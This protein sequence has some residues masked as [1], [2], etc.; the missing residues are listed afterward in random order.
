MS[1]TNNPEYDKVLEG[2]FNSI[3]ERER[4]VHHI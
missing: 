2:Y 1:Y 3:N 4:V